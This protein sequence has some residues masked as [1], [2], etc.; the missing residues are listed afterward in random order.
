MCCIAAINQRLRNVI[1]AGLS[2]RL[3]R[4]IARPARPPSLPPSLPHLGQKSHSLVLHPPISPGSVLLLF[5]TTHIST[6]HVHTHRLSIVDHALGD[7]CWI[8]GP[9]GAEEIFCR[10][11]LPGF[12]GRA[13]AAVLWGVAKRDFP[14]VVGEGG[15]VRVDD[16][17][18][19][20][21]VT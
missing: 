7:S 2:H 15:T 17:S 12:R 19:D 3:W 18:V 8:R 1:P 20:V 13:D 11:V 6:H 10:G 21:R 14:L 4:L 16:R 9:R 5:L